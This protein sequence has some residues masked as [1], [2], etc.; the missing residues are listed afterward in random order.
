MSGLLRALKCATWRAGRCVGM[1]ML[2]AVGFIFYIMIING[3][4]FTVANIV[5]RFPQMVVFVGSIMYL[6]YGIV[7]TVTYV[8][9]AMSCGCTRKNIFFSAV[10]MHVFELA[11]TELVLALYYLVVPAEWSMASAGEMCM[12]VLYLFVFDMGLS[13]TLG[14]LVKR[15]GKIAYV[16]FVVLCSV[17]GGLVGGLV[18]F[19]GTEIFSGIIPHASL[20]IPFAAFVWY[21]L[22]AALF[23]L[24]I[25]KIEVRI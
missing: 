11:V 6:A 3:T 14:I 8:Q 18:G 22:M 25:R 1:A 5:G 15:F 9:Y 20:M 16:V 21:G 23:W 13:L 10:Y 12:T 4:R 17:L 24:F 2:M 19:F 7:D